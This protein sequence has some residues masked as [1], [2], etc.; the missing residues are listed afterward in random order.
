MYYRTS[1][2][3]GKDKRDYTMDPV[4]S[5]LD[6]NLDFLP[7]FAAFRHRWEKSGRP[8]LSKETFLALRHKIYVP[9]QMRPYRVPDKFKP[10]VDRQITELLEMGLIRPSDSPMASP[11]V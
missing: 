4:R 2:G 9:R 5:S 6:W 11:I 3:K 7:E 8:R 10:E 1:R